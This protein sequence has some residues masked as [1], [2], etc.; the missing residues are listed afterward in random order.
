[1]TQDHLKITDSPFFRE[2]YDAGVGEESQIAVAEPDG[3][4]ISGTMLSKVTSF[5]RS[6]VTVINNVVENPL[7]TVSGA[8]CKLIDKF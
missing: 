3:G 7:A 5:G 1:M 6:F 4:D 2:G 8:A